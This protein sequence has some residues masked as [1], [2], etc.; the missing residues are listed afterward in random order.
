MADANPIHLGHHAKADGRWRIYVFADREVAGSSPVV[1]ELARWLAESP[2]SPV[3]AY[4]PADAD[5]DAW[6]DVKVVYQQDHTQV[7][8]GAVP[9][10]FKPRV[11]PFQLID[12]EKVYAALPE[13]DI[14]D[15]RGIDRG[16]AI[17]VV[18]PDQYVADVLPLTATAELA[19]FFEPIM[20]GR[21][22]AHV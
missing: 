20:S 11:G 15:V 6:F 17:V 1:T 7:D 13:D 2:E 18:R 4:T 16:G 8:I 5:P 10:A 12:Y 14:F 9:D 22:A 21:R 3:V 19:A